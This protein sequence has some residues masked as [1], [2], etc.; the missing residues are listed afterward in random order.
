MEKTEDIIARVNHFLATE[1]E[2][3]EAAISP[4]ADMRKVLDMDSLDFIDL[5]VVLEKN[6]SFKVNPEDFERFAT[7]QDFYDYVV[8]KLKEK[9]PA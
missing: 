6:F 1:F 3:D 5:V 9:E 4:E 8:L 7:F 2:V